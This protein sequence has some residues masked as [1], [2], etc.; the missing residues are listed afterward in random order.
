MGHPGLAKGL[1][2]PLRKPPPIPPYNSES[3]MK[4]PIFL[5]L[6]ALVFAV[7]SFAAE[8]TATLIEESVGSGDSAFRVKIDQE[9]SEVHVVQE[10]P[11]AQAGAVKV[12]LLRKNQKPLEV[13]LKLMEKKEELFQYTGKAGPWSG[14]IVGFELEWSFDKKTWKKLKKILP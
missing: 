4:T 12:R 2:W 13:K 11:G 10:K 8:E 6:S 3:M 14:S 7:A 5:I 1:Q 9:L